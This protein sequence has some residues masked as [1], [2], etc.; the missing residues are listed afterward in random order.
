MVKK[1]KKGDICWIEDYQEFGECLVLLH[2]RLTKDIDGNPM[3]AMWRCWL[4]ANNH[5]SLI[6]F[7]MDEVPHLCLKYETELKEVC[8]HSST[9]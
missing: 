7:Y 2:Q 6:G 3:K 9:H 4:I 8:S 5:K 1:F